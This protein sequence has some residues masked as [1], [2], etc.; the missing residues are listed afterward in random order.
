MKKTIFVLA[1]ILLGNL[2]Y[3]Q[4][5]FDLG[6][7]L[8]ISGVKSQNF[9]T[10]HSN[11]S[12]NKIDTQYY[13]YGVSG[14]GVGVF[15]YPKYHIIQVAGHSISLGAPITLGVSSSYNSR[16][17]EESS[18]YIYDLNL[19]LDING[20][21]LN[22]K[23]DNSDKLI[24]YYVGIGF[25]TINTGGIGFDLEA[26]SKT[27][28]DDLIVVPLDQDAYDYMTVKNT[29][30]LI[31]AG[32]TVPFFFNKEKSKNMGIRAFVKPG[33]GPKAPTY[34]GASVFISFGKSAE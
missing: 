28:T 13:T 12:T 16:T 8:A 10:Q 14:S 29:G 32:A 7:T 4:F 15:A 33:F 1:F 18:S 3:S 34:F 20:G 26:S 22:K 30:L 17:G 31:H 19:A 5:Q 11:Y 21:R 25:G 24:G 27:N 9:L 6:V 2:C 23:K